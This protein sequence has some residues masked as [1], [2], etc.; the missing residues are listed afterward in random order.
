MENLER[1]VNV[2]KQQAEAFLLSAKEFYP[3]GTYI[4]YDGE[5]VPVGAYLEGDFPPSL[6][7]IDLLEKDF[8]QLVEKGAYAIAAIAIDVRLTE[9]GIIYDGIEMRFLNRKRKC[10]KGT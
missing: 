9:N 7:L 3:F 10:I 1:I 8:K 5:I 4:N 2:L 6:P